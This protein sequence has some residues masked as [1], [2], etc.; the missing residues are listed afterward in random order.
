M[1]GFNRNIV[2]M[3]T[4]SWLPDL[5]DLGGPRY[6]ALADALAR[7]IGNGTLAPGTRLPTHRELAWQLGVT[8]GT[9]SRGYAEA[10]R[11]GL[12]AGEV[13]RG[14]FVQV[15][16]GIGA[17]ATPM[18]WPTSDAIGGNIVNL[19]TNAP[20]V[21][22]QEKLFAE[23]LVRLA[24]DPHLARLLVYPP[25]LGRREMREAA[26]AWLGSTTGMTV[27][28]EQVFVTAGAQNALMVAFHLVARPGDTVLVERLT[29]PGIKAVA[30]TMQVRLAGVDMDGE[31]M[32]PDALDAAL[33]AHSA[34]LVVCVPTLQNPTGAVMGE[35]RR[36]AIAEVCDGHG[37]PI[38]EDG[39]Y[40]F[41]A[42]HQPG[43]LMRFASTPGFFATSLSKA[44]SPALRCGFLIAPPEMADEATR[45]MAASCLHAPLLMTECARRWMID[46][47]IAWSESL[48]RK[49]AMAR[50]ALAAERLVGHELQ[51][52]PASF[53]TW[54]TL[55]DPWRPADFARAAEARG[56]LV[57]P[58]E[59]FAIGR[60]PAPFA[61]RASLTGAMTRDDL[62]AGLDALAG[63]L[64]SRPA[65][66]RAVV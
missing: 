47:R 62:A 34:R 56:V 57:T 30:R 1:S 40:D 45:I 4:L 33:R 41:L 25:N 52:H 61:V 6:Q 14:T 11:R 66:Y 15:D 55:P 2:T 58:A 17:R 50:Q 23:E 37:V 53:H 7:D 12:I 42:D 18:I 44:I 24:G 36:R 39:I 64:E 9:V 63:L 20:P 3:T 48:V 32:L 51:A 46:D 59:S 54:I 35:E 65:P 5:D 38:L 27:A 60:D 49:E 19:A 26:A 31:G 21:C 22:G 13:G 28:P 29:Y 10:T 8:V 43:P 16:G